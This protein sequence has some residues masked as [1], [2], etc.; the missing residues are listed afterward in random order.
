MLY[1]LTNTC[2][3]DIYDYFEAILLLYV[4]TTLV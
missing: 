3:F 4:L 2:V 1:I